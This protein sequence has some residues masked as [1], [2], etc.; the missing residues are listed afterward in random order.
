MQLRVVDASSSLFW[1]L[2]EYTNR[3]LIENFITFFFSLL[4]ILKSG[5]AVTLE[6]C[7][8]QATTSL[9]CD[10]ELLHTNER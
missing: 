1:S 8:K 7:S 4:R 9:K 10:F 2:H 6:S 3:R 5:N